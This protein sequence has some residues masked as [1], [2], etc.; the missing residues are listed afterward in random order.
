MDSPRLRGKRY[1]KIAANFACEIVIH[2]GV[3]GYARHFACRW[4]VIDRMSL[5]LPQGKAAIFENV[6]SNWRR[7]IF[8]F[9]D[10]YCDQLALRVTRSFPRPEFTRGLDDKPN[11]FLQIAARLRQSTPLCVHAG[12]FFYGGDV[13]LSAFFDD[14]SELSFDSVLYGNSLLHPVRGPTWAPNCVRRTL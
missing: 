6:R 8:S 3:A 1:A 13:P 5:A 14:G 11:G 7:F 2:F 12:N 4:I 9:S 10:P